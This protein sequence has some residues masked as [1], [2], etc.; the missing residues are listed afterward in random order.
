MCATWASIG[1]CDTNPAFMKIQCPVTCR[2][3]QSDDC[4]DESDDCEARPY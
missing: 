3:C 1:E 2:L 4:F